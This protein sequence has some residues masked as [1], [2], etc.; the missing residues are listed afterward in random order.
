MKKELINNLVLMTRNY[1]YNDMISQI[2]FEIIKKNR[3]FQYFK[4]PKI[5]NIWEQKDTQSSTVKD[6]YATKLSIITKVEYHE[7]GILK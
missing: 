7:V 3:K 4:E 5:V 2:I 1:Y 6:D